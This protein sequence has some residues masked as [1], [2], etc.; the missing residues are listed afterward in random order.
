MVVCSMEITSHPLIVSGQE[1]SRVMSGV[2]FPDN[3]LFVSYASE[4]I[5]DTRV[6]FLSIF[7]FHPYFLECAP[8]EYAILKMPA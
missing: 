2:S 4:N 1:V 6:F 7:S 3:G 8:L 5:R